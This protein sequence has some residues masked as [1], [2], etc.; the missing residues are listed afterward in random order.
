[1]SGGQNG[2]RLPPGAELILPLLITRPYC[3]SSVEHAGSLIATVQGA[4]WQMAH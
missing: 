4:M 2:T 1:M 3:L